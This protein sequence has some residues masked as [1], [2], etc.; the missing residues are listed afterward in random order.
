M[1]G[2]RRDDGLPVRSF[3][4]VAGSL[5]HQQPRTRDLLGQGLAMLEREHRVGRA[6]DHQ[7]GRADRGQRLP[8]RG[9]VPDS[10]VVLQRR[11]VACALDV[12]A[13]QLAGGRLVEGRRPRPER[14]SNRPGID[15]RG[16][17]RP[18]HLRRCH[19]PPELLG[20]RWQARC[21]AP[22]GRADQDERENAMAKST[23]TSCANAPP[24]DTPTTCAAGIL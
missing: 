16:S 17:I 24:A 3:D 22:R 2:D 18:I 19:E 4:A 9:I 21:P 11:E 12:A 10:V 13:D 14:A 5:E 20:R 7:R 15:H 1:L 8:E 23:A 6:V